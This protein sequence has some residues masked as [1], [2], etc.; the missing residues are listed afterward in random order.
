MVAQVLEAM[1]HPGFDDMYYSSSFNLDHG[2]QSSRQGMHR[3]KC[4]RV[5]QVRC[6]PTGEMQ[7]H[8]YG[9]EV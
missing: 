4:R 2:T 3:K 5:C 8:S 7:A 6:A 1:T 9:R